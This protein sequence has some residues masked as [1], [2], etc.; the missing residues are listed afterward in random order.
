MLCNVIRVVPYET[1]AHL[2]VHMS[3]R[4]DISVFCTCGLSYLSYLFISSA[5]FSAMVPRMI[6]HTRHTDTLSLIQYGSY[7]EERNF[8][9]RKPG[10]DQEIP[11]ECL[12]M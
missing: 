1:L 3:R 9:S 2:T 11:L 8:A 7:L 10:F 4:S 6:D 5:S 12:Q